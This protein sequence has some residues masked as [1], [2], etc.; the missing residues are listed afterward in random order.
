MSTLNHIISA[1]SIVLLFQCANP[2]TPTGGAKDVLPPIIK[3]TTPTDRSSNIKPNIIVFRFNEFIQASNIKEQIVI[4]P[5]TNGK[6]SINV[7]KDNVTIKFEGDVFNDNTTY[8][9][10]LNEAIKDLNE[11]NQG[12]YKPLLFSTGNTLDTQYL[13]GNCT[14]I[15]EPKSK[16]VRIQSLNKPNYKSIAN[17]DLRFS[18][19]GL[20]SDSITIIAYND[21]NG[22][23]SFESNE[24][25]GMLKTKPGDTCSIFIYSVQK[26]KLNLYNFKNNKY[27][28]NGI[29]TQ[30]ENN[31]IINYKDTLIGDSISLFGLLQK[32]DS[33]RYIIPKKAENKA[34]IL[35][36]SLNKPSFLA[37]SFQQIKLSANEILQS[38]SK[39][40]QTYFDHN[41]MVDSC[42]T[43]FELNTAVLRFKNNHTG[44]VRIPFN[45][46]TESGKEIKDTFKTSIPVYT[47]LTIYNNEAFDIYITLKNKVSGET[48]IS[49]IENGKN[50]KLWVQASE[51][52]LSYFHDIN[53]NQL[54][55]A[56]DITKETLGEY[57]KKLPT[58]K[59]KENMA[60]DL[61]VKDT[62]K[63]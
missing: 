52:E 59:I 61:Y 8:S 1:L 13:F 28:L 11:G 51:H 57:Y 40:T 10:H 17:K 15:E 47:P 23:D 46:V 29:K 56:P 18:L 26:K 33:T 36:Y 55:D 6:P 50:I 20:P 45:L 12:I 2:V 21:L 43:L 24:D 32:I 31:N 39:E 44:N 16:K 48:Y 27:G 22:N 19:Y 53:K 30:S 54:L 3:V 58:I 5:K 25:V 62:E 7:G 14:F 41:N 38:T 42:N 60:V 37:D 9:I 63:P 49:S 34:F 35:R 4:S